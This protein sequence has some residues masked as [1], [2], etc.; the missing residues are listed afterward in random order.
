MIIFRIDDPRIIANFFSILCGQKDYQHIFFLTVNQILKSKGGCDLVFLLRKLLYFGALHK[1]LSVNAS[2]FISNFPDLCPKAIN[3]DGNFSAGKKRCDTLPHII[4]FH[5]F[6]I[7]VKFIDRLSVILHSHYRKGGFRH[8]YG[9]IRIS[10]IHN[11]T[12]N[13]KGSEKYRYNNGPFQNNF[14]HTKISR[15]DGTCLLF[16]LIQQLLKGSVHMEKIGY[17]LNSCI[18]ALLIFHCSYQY[19]LRGMFH[20]NKFKDLGIIAPFL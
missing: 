9:H 12:D 15:A 6:I 2:D 5:H 13:K 19:I 16:F 4:D 10:L 17:L 1:A 14:L 7:T 18:P 3:L 20:V 11:F 8:L